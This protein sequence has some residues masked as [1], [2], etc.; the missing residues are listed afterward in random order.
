MLTKR[1]KTIALTTLLLDEEEKV[2]IKLKYR[3]NDYIRFH[4]GFMGERKKMRGLYTGS[5][6]QSL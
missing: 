3:K 5:S 6:S 4:H 1:N 2:K